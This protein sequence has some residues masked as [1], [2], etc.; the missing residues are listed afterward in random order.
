MSRAED[1]LPPISPTPTGLY[2]HHKGGWYAVVGDARCSETLQGMALYLDLAGSDA[3]HFWVRPGAMFRETVEVAGR[4]VP[5]FAAVDE[6]QLAV[7]DVVTARAVIAW[8][9]WQ[10][11]QAG[12]PFRPP[13]PEP[14][15]CCGRG[16][17]GCVWEGYHQALQH[18]RTEVRQ[19]LEP[20]T[21]SA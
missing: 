16:C 18:W 3:G 7:A 19:L 9:K 1:E 17:N 20:T 12:L 15:S 5:R 4:Q 14:T 13:P 11:K 8:R 6:A 10:L 21:V 2:R